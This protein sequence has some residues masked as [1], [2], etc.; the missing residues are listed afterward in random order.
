MAVSLENIVL[1][2]ASPRRRR[3]LAWLGLRYQVLATDSPESLD[4]PLALDSPALAIS[5]ALE[6]LEAA[7]ATVTDNSLVMAF[8]TIVVLD[9]ELLGKPTD[10]ADARRML[11][12]LADRTHQVVTGC[13]MRHRAS[14]FSVRFAVVSE[15]RMRALPPERINRWLASGEYLGCA[16]A[17]NIE[18]QIAEVGPG[19]CFQNVAGLPLCHVY[20]ALREVFSADVGGGGRLGLLD[21]IARC[22]STLGRTCRLGPSV[23]GG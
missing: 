15:V 13:A 3:L 14:D 2:S 18:N 10:E 23:V 21:P 5:L 22:D 16:G 9:G 17:Y 4:S 6:K 19:D 7:G 12:A 8:D 20:S 1:A 11:A